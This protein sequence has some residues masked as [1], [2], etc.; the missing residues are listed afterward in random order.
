M[1]IDKAVGSGDDTFNTFFYETGAGKHVPHAMFVDLE[2]TVN[3]Q[4]GTN[5]RQSPI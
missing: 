4:F 5:H 1:P 2:P 3:H